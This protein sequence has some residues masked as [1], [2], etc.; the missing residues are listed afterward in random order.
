MNTE[1]IIKANIPLIKK[2]A[3]K[4][5]NASF[6]DLFQA[7]CMGVLKAYRNYQNN[8]VTKFSTYAYDYIFGEMYEC[9]YKNQKLKVS[10]DLLRLA[11]KIDVAKDVMNQKLHR[12]ATY[13]EIANFLGLDISL[14]Y[15]AINCSCEPVSLDKSLDDDKNYYETIPSYEALS[16][17]EKLT[18]QDGL[19]NLSKEEQQ[20]ILWR[21]FEDMTQTQ[22]ARKLKMT[23]VKVS[24]YEKKSLE[25]LRQYYDVT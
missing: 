7:G 25:K 14:I 17:D 18:L 23:Q 4:F 11:R 13:E 10:K 9:V 12:Q 16:L 20:I 21:Y 2:I 24:R 22:I 6:E 1:D 3:T 5:Y 8:G 19:T 15:E